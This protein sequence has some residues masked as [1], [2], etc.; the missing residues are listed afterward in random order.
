M[1]YWL[2]LQHLASYVLITSQR[3]GSFTRCSVVAI[4]LQSHTEEQADVTRLLS[5]SP[6]NTLLF[7]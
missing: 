5:C 2:Y 6:Q 4:T 3:S 1:Y 7:V